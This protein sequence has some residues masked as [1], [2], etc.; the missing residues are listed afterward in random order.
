MNTPAL[1]SLEEILS[2]T[3]EQIAALDEQLAP[4]VMLVHRLRGVAPATREVGPPVP[5]KVGESKIV[6]TPL[7]RVR[8]TVEAVNPSG[9]VILAVPGMDHPA[10]YQ[11]SAA[12]RE[13][14]AKAKVGDKIMIR[15]GEYVERPNSRERFALR[16]VKL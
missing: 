4:I 14:L 7:H 11:P 16:G 5:A 15:S 2:Y 8:A 13:K 1:P 12:A 9:R 10:A 3:D 6:S